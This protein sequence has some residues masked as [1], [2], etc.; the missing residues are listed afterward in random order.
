MSIYT[1][2]IGLIELLTKSSKM[3]EKI[4]KLATTFNINLQ[5]LNPNCGKLVLSKEQYT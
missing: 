2:K 1:N 4:N 3:P 5:T